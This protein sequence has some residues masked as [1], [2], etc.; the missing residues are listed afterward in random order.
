MGDFNLRDLLEFR[1]EEGVIS[2]KESRMVLLEAT[3]LSYLKHDLIYTLGQNI[4]QGILFR[5]GYRCGSYDAKM[6]A[7][8]YGGEIKHIGLGPAI[9]R[10]KGNGQVKV[11]KELRFGTNFNRYYAEGKW[12]N[13]HEAEHYKK[14][15]GLSEF[16]ICWIST[17]Y[18]SGFTSV[19]TGQEVICLEK[20]ALAWAIKIAAGRYAPGIIGGI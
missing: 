14:L 9:Y 4:A 19:I 17:G 15:Y 13:C 8:D 3:A 6:V 20:H 18:A 5:F 1:P 10:W 12:E 11:I 16:P 7:S 2:L